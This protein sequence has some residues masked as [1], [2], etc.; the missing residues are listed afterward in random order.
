MHTYRP[1][2]YCFGGWTR[3]RQALRNPEGKQL[4][5]NHSVERLH[6]AA[7]SDGWFRYAT[8]GVANLLALL[9]GVPSFSDANAA[10]SP[11]YNQL[12]SPRTVTEMDEQ[13]TALWRG[14]GSG[15]ALAQQEFL[16]TNEDRSET[17]YLLLLFP[18]L[19]LDRCRVKQ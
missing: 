9:I 18:T 8:G 2:Q 17:R 12:K 4:L 11:F 1:G 7:K 6:F 5:I 15:G 3:R 19:V 10:V 16:S 13:G 14:E